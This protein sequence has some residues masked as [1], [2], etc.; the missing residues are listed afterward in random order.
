[1]RTG[2]T[3]PE[4]AHRVAGTGVDVVEGVLIDINGLRAAVASADAVIHAACTFTRPEV[5]V[6]AMAVMVGA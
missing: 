2:P 1:M 6:A 3:R 4:S 5:D